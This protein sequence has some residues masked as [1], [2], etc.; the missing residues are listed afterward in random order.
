[1][2]ECGGSNE[3][4]G[5]G[6]SEANSA[7]GNRGVGGAQLFPAVYDALR[8]LARRM[9]VSERPDHTLQ[10]T[11]L[12]NEAY[13]RLGGD[14]SAIWQSRSQFYQAAAVAMRRILIEHAR[15]R[16][17]V[18]R[19]GRL[20][21]IPS[22]VLDLAAA[23]EAHD[24]LLLDDAIEALQRESPDVAQL[25]RLRFYAGLSIDQTAE[26]L[27]KSPRTVDRDWAY[28]RAW[29]HQKL[30]SGAGTEPQ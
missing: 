23:P 7:K 19:G 15:S 24:V 11:A 16:K 26:V 27:G 6:S 5:D 2:A 9:M 14:N 30:S 17:R 4:G 18:R 1:M 22:S 29:L 21:R 13:L 10:P 3:T 28:G 25:V 20:H 12:V 8:A